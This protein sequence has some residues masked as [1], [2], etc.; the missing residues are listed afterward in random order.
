MMLIAPARSIATRRMSAAILVVLGFLATVIADERNAQAQPAPLTPPAAEPLPKPADEVARAH[1]DAGNA[2]FRRAQGNTDPAIQRTEYQNAAREYLAAV[3]TESKYLYTLYWNLGHTYRQLGEYTRARHFYNKF[4]E[5]APSRFAAQRTA[6]EDHV[7]TMAAELDKENALGLPEVNP[8]RDS[9]KD[10]SL[11]HADASP[12]QDTGEGPRWYKDTIGWTLVGS[13]AAASVAGV[14]LYQNS[15][16]LFDQAKVEDRQSVQADL[17][18]RA[19]FRRGAGVVTGGLGVACLV[20]G[21]IKLVISSQPQR[22]P[23]RASVVVGASSISI[24]GSF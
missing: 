20:A 16:S 10:S 14:G 8:P 9:P 11:S 23:A 22:R 19:R 4:L 13:G 18:E 3:K 17:E 2:A 21:T 15:S 12:E 6:A 5:F 1:F 24:V 7:R